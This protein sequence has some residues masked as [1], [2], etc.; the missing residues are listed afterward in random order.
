M[1][2]VRGHVY[3]VE[4]GTT[5]DSYVESQAINMGASSRKISLRSLTEKSYRTI[6]MH[7]AWKLDDPQVSTTEF[8]YSRSLE[9]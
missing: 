4:V 3:E 8:G 5:Y 9:R 2:I 6:P 7:Q 1:G